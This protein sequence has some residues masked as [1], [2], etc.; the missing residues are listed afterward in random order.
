M[1]D[2]DFPPHPIFHA[3]ADQLA[4]LA[5]LLDAFPGQQGNPHVL[6]PIHPRVRRAWAEQLI[7]RGV[8]VV[9][10]LMKQL[11]V[12]TGE[13]PE[14]TWLQPM[15]W[16]NRAE[17]EARLAAQAEAAAY[18]PA[19]KADAIA[20]QE[21]QM[22]DVL[23]ATKPSLLEQIEALTDPE[24]RAAMAARLEPEIPKHINAIQ[25][26]VEQIERARAETAERETEDG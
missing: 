10:E 2:N 1:P 7:A 26:A 25:A 8:V 16:V 21:A 23:R 14:A 19:E 24:A 4:M 12:A 9:P 5:A 17:Y 22:K 20:Q 15:E 11:P 3:E 6:V 13:H 18:A